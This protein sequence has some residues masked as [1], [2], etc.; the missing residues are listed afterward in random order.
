MKNLAAIF[1]CIGILALILGAVL[2]GFAANEIYF[3]RP[4]EG[5]ETVTVVIPEGA[6]Q[7]EISALLA[8]GR[9]VSSRV[10]FKLYTKWR[11]VDTQFQHG[12]FEIV[13]GTSIRKIVNQL[14]VSEADETTITVIEGWTIREMAAYLAEKTD[15][16]AE[17]YKT[18][19]EARAWQDEFAFLDIKPSG[20]DL[21]GFLFP[22]TYRILKAA[23]AED[24]IRKQLITFER[25]VGEIAYD[26]LILASIVEREVRGEEDRR[27]VAD[28]F[29]R[30]IE[31]GI[32]LQADS[33]VN[34]ITGKN[35][36]SISYEDTKIDSPYN[37]YKYR[38]LPPGPISNP[39]LESINAVRNPLPNDFFYF[40]TDAEGDV[41]YAKTL[42]EHNRNKS[43]YLQ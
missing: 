5:A 14:T 10:L 30:R 41:H 40:L 18:S 36:P 11:G 23:S 32:G 25:R 12:I 17:A 6:T 8:N 4:A 35:T 19:A 38:G 24:V 29:K 42:E 31:A 22:D 3:L 34:Y 43:Q 2:V 13:R 28:L 33:T 9:L 37:T 16:T 27:M 15:V 26:D 39:G 21:E 1:F 20:H 7:G